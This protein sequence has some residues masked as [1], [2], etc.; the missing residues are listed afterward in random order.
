[1]NNQKQLASKVVKAITSFLIEFEGAKTKPNVVFITLEQ[2]E[3]VIKYFPYLISKDRQFLYNKNEYRVIIVSDSS[4][5]GAA[6]SFYTDFIE[7][8]T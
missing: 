8:I 4:V 2:L 3:A 6:F 1:M 7:E 5:V